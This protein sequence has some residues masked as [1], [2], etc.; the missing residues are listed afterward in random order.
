MTDVVQVGAEWVPRLG[1]MEVPRERAELISGLY[2]LAAWVADHPELPVPR[3]EARIYTGDPASAWE[4]RAALV[5]LAAASLDVEPQWRAGGGHYTAEGSFG[6]VAFSAT[7]IT[8][9]HMAAY[10]A[11]MSYRDNVTPDPTD[12]PDVTQAGA[13]A[14][15]ATGAG[16][17]R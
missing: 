12:V 5:E 15:G 11:H 1:L 7:A 2:E 9:E 4:P 16:G 3:V 6:P 14:A 10:H 13:T 17:S 8:G